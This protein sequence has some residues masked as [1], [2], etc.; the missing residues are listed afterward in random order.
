MTTDANRRA[1]TWL[2]YGCTTVSLA[3]NVAYYAGTGPVGVALAAVAPILLPVGVHYIPKAAAVRRGARFVVTLAVIVAATA[4]FVLSFEALSGLAREHGHGGWTAYLLPIA[5]DVLAAA[6]A[7]ALVVDPASQSEH[8]SESEEPVHQAAPEHELVYPTTSAWL[9]EAL[10]AATLELDPSVRHPTPEQP[11]HHAA[12][13]APVI[14]TPTD[15]P[16]PTSADALVH[17]PSAAVHQAPEPAPVHAVERPRLTAVQTDAGAPAAPK[18]LVHQRT[19]GEAEQ[20]PEVLPVHQAQA[21]AV[22]QAGGSELPVQTIA[23]VYA[24]LDAGQSQT[25]IDKVKVCNKRTV[26]KLIAARE[27][28]SDASA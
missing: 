24:R 28:L 11:V 26:A 5:V 17:A 23:A 10:A 6:A 7:Y 22:V 4:A 25:Y 16:A 14:A 19:S 18:T 9:D 13:T 2:L 1:F 12:E 27:A 21:E 3:G 20:A 15:A 8:A